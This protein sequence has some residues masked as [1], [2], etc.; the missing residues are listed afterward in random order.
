MQS[1]GSRGTKR[2]F[3]EA[4]VEHVSAEEVHVLRMNVNNTPQ[5]PPPLPLRK[6]IP[7]LGVQRVLHGKTLGIE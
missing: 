6:S 4:T 5:P 2:S 7:N 1:V 3:Q